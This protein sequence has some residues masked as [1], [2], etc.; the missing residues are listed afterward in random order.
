MGNRLFCDI[1]DTGVRSVIKRMMKILISEEICNRMNTTGR[2][3]KLSANCD[4]SSV[5]AIKTPES[6]IRFLA[7]CSG[8][9]AS[10][11]EEV[12]YVEVKKVITRWISDERN[13]KFLRRNRRL[14][15]RFERQMMNMNSPLTLPP[16]VSLHPQID[17][18]TNMPN[19][20]PLPLMNMLNARL[21]RPLLETRLGRPPWRPPPKNFLEAASTLFLEAASNFFFGGRLQ[22]FFFGGRLQIF[23]V[24][25]ENQIFRR[26]H[27][28]KME[29]FANE[30]FSMKIFRK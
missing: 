5:K 25:A 6:I 21:H 20:P 3:S 13:N 18:I 1:S 12:A 8:H 10:I 22:F 2:S 15:Q 19:N 27:F 9:L 11:N 4:G 17:H 24:E 26:K 7:K 14:K 30:N 29:F 16:V 28:S 23:F